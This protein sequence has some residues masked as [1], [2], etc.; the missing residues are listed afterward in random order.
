MSLRAITKGEIGPRRAHA[1]RRWRTLLALLWHTLRLQRR[2]ALIWGLALG[3]YSAAIVATFP[4]FGDAE[5]MDQLVRMYPE[6]MREAFNIEDMGTP[7][8]S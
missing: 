5:Q 2:G 7:R 8:G 4:T 1:R 6:G 3:L